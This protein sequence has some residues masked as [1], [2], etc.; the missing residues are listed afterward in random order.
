MGTSFQSSMNNLGHHFV[1]EVLA[2][3]ISEPASGTADSPCRHA[4]EFWRET[5]SRIPLDPSNSR[6]RS[7]TTPHH[8]SLLARSTF[9]GE[10]SG[11]DS[12]GSSGEQAMEKAPAPL[13]TTGLPL[14]DVLEVLTERSNPLVDGE[15]VD[16]IVHARGIARHRIEVDRQGA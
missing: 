1:V 5:T 4:A 16:Q 7:I 10:A 2:Q 14:M 13:A 15:L 3:G 11:A 12:T 6:S 9:A 8:I